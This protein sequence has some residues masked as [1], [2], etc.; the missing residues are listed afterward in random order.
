[1]IKNRAARLCAIIRARS[2]T[3]K[4]NMKNSAACASRWKRWSGDV[5]LNARLSLR[6]CGSAI[7][8]N[9]RPSL[10]ETVPT[11]GQ[12]LTTW[13]RRSPEP[14]TPPSL[15][16]G[17][18]VMRARTS[19]FIISAVLLVVAAFWIWK[20]VISGPRRLAGRAVI[21]RSAI[22]QHGRLQFWRKNP[23]ARLRA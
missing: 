9:R 16:H 20:H 3:F 12:N 21:L 22:R 18:P 4:T 17:K 2:P 6:L 23:P 14:A 7:F 8:L 1:M 19:D 11:G 5:K 10:T 15:T 13:G